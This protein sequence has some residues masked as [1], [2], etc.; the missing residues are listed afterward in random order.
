[1]GRILPGPIKNRAGYGFLKKNP[2]RV[3]VGSGFYQKTRNPTR[4]P[5]RIKP[6]YIYIKLL[7]YPHI[8]IVKNPKIFYSFPHF[9]LSTH[10]SASPSS[11]LSSPHTRPQQTESSTPLIFL[12]SSLHGLY[13]MPPLHRR[14]PTPP[15]HKVSTLSTPFRPR[16]HRSCTV[17]QTAQSSSPLIFLAHGHKRDTASLHLILHFFSFSFFLFFLGSVRLNHVNLCLC[18]CL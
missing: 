14:Y 7:N 5:T 17:A 9:R 15:P 8:Y 18:F 6:G 16:R 12:T 11:S 4:N 3:R 13:P 1:M 10:T 2:K